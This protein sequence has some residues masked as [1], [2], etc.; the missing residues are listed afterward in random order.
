MLKVLIIV[1]LFASTCL[2]LNPGVYGFVSKKVIENIKDSAWPLVKE[3]FANIVVPGSQKIDVEIGHITIERLG[4]QIDVDASAVQIDLDSANNSI[5]ATARNIQLSGNAHWILKVLWENS[6][7]LSLTGTV[8]SLVADVKLDNQQC[9]DGF[10][11]KITFENISL[12][13]SSLNIDTSSSI[14]SPVI[15]VIASLLNDV[16]KK[17]INSQLSNNGSIKSQLNTELNGLITKNYPVAVPIKELGVAISTYV[18]S[19]VTIYDTGIQ[20]PLE[21]FVYNMSSGYK[22]IETCPVMTDYVD[23]KNVPN[24]FYAALGDC[25]VR[26]AIDAL[27]SSQFQ[28]NVKINSAIANVDM[29]MSLDKWDQ[30]TVEFTKDNLKLGVGIIAN[31]KI[32]TY[33]VKASAKA[34]VNVSITKKSGL[35]KICQNKPNLRFLSITNKNSAYSRCPYDTKHFK[36]SFPGIL[37]DQAIA[38][39][40]VKIKFEEI[41][42]LVATGIPDFQIEVLKKLLLGNDQTTSFDVPQFCIADEICFT[43]L[44]AAINDKFISADANVNFKPF[45]SKLPLSMEQ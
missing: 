20:V 25:T 15:N 7:N 41:D 35:H 19:D 12:D 28:Y 37:Q 1:S 45:M 33:D 22:Q 43:Q 30:E 6:G 3:Q 42:D 32:S 17:E 18:T 2:A 29:M 44:D 24:D 4:I 8:G 5:R 27:I 36:E 40:D 10:V 38:S 16:I 31:G 9:K 11:P 14:L 13:I 23:P 21:G 34:L 39:Y 26:S